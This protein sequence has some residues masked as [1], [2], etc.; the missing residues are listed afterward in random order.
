[1]EKKT[2]KGS[3]ASK[4]ASALNKVLKE[5]EREIKKFT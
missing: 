4:K 1:M 5:K 2:K 3:A